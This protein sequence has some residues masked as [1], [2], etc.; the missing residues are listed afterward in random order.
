MKILFCAMKF[1]YGDPKRGYSYEYYNYLPTFQK[2]GHQVIPFDY[3]SLYKKIGKDKMN[4]LLWKTVKMLRPHLLFCSLFEEQFKKGII[5][6]I[7]KTKTATLTWFYDDTWRFDNF[8]RLWA[9]V[10]NWIA[11]TEEFMVEKYRKIGSNA[12]YLPFAINPKVYKPYKVTKSYD[13]TFVGGPHGFRN[14]YYEKLKSANIKTTFFGESW[15]GRLSYKNM[16]KLFSSSKINLNFTET[17]YQGSILLWYLRRF[18]LIP[19]IHQHKARIFEITGSG[20]FELSGWT[21]GIEKLYEPG[22]EIEIF[23]S[24]DELIEKCRYYLKNSKQKEKIAQ[25]GYQ[26][27]LKDHTYEKRFSRL[28]AKIGLKNLSR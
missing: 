21:K 28:F 13:V 15:A 9:P 6:E 1:D 8:C 17:S 14:Q 11:T 5:A 16:V 3:M 2:L 20:G 7:S 24:T 22:K 25:A 4:D 27:T 10:F 12:I 18:R 26:R 19:R 23:K